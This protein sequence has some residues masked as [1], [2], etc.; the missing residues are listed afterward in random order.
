MR[1]F[2]YFV[3]THSSHDLLVQI[4]RE[5][6][7]YYFNV[8]PTLG[9]RL[10]FAGN[11]VVFMLV[12][13]LLVLCC[14]RYVGRI[15]FCFLL[16]HLFI[17]GKA[18]L[19]NMICSQRFIKTVFV[20]HSIQWIKKAIRRKQIFWMTVRA[21]E[22][23][24]TE[25]HGTPYSLWSQLIVTV[26]VCSKLWMKK[27][28]LRDLTGHLDTRAVILRWVLTKVITRFPWQ[29]KVMCSQVVYS[30]GKTFF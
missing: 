23:W 2:K 24:M 1:T 30:N 5:N 25:V 27:V 22:D 28:L 13:M 10:V 9:K 12:N 15:L 4:L 11:K 7:K 17:H 8:R 21:R 20:Y 26:H 6:T 14:W 3:F 18:I 19:T 29:V 16:M